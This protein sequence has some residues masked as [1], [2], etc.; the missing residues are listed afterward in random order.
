[1]SDPQP[2]QLSSSALAT[3]NALLQAKNYPAMYQAIGIGITELR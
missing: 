1:M 2:I 3:V